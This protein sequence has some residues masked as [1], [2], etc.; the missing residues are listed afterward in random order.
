M[1]IAKA[2]GIGRASVYRVLEPVQSQVSVVRY[3]L[4][5]TSSPRLFERAR[6]TGFSLA[7]GVA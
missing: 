3:A 5:R 1:A 4:N 7:V 6:L 2:L